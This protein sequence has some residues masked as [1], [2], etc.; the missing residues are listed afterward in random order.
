ME[1]STKHQAPMIK[2][3]QS[4]K[5]QTKAAGEDDQR[6]TRN[7]QLGTAREAHSLSEAESL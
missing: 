4:T 7:S 5:F 2:Q 1:S 3:S 6:G